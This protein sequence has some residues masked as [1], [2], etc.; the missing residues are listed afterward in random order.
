MLIKIICCYFSGG[1]HGCYQDN[2]A[3]QAPHI[4]LNT[5]L[6]LC[7]LLLRSR[8]LLI[9]D[10]VIE[11]YFYDYFLLGYGF[12]EYLLTTQPA[13]STSRTKIHF[14]IDQAQSLWILSIEY[15]MK[16]KACRLTK[17]R[18]TIANLYGW[19]FSITS[20]HHRQWSSI[21]KKKCYSG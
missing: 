13:S 12:M 19:T 4:T 15:W 8:S 21:G 9:L 3:Y 11:T 7:Q 5:I 2:M 10:C 16:W 1:D 14:Q 20:N 17:G 6:P 18:S